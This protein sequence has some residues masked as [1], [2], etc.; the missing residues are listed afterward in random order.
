MAVRLEFETTDSQE[1]ELAKRY[2]AMDEEGAYLERVADLLP[3]REITQA[4]MVAK[5]VRQICTAYDENQTCPKCDGQIQIGG[6]TEAKK[7]IQ[8]S[9]QPC[10]ECQKIQD[11]ERQKEEAQQRAEL[12]AKLAPYI[13]RAREATISYS[14]LPDDTVLILQA[15]HALVGPLLTQGTFSLDDCEAMTPQGTG[16]LID[17]LYKQN[18]LQDDPAAAK[19]GTYWIQDEKLWFSKAS[20][21]YFLPPDADLGGSQAALNMLFEREFSDSVALTELWLDHAVTDVMCYFEY[22]CDVHNHILCAADVDKIKATVRHGM[23]KYSVAQM[24]FIMWKVTR[25]AAA[26]ASR[27]YYN[28][29]TAATTIPNKIRKQL[30]NAD[31]GTELRNE[32]TRPEPHITGSLGMMFYSLF[33]LDEYTKGTDAQAL[34]D[35]LG[36]KSGGE[37]NLHALAAAFMKT[38][39]ENE[40]ALFA[41]EDFAEMVR[42]GLTTEDALK[43]TIDRNPGLFQ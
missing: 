33:G 35:R 13:S 28:R 27:S 40:S 32:W 37:I 38:A 41:L 36:E 1:I 9:N 26:L 39:L 11:E 23:R 42:V 30:E 17:R 20:A 25:D 7:V 43:E 19:P 18:I 3:F 14:A 5:F 8:R 34:F 2:W 15:I 21:R 24:W 31:Q 10:E 29:E 12:D 16:G 4:S 6:R 22:Q